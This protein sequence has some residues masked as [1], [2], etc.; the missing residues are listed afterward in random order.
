MQLRGNGAA[1]AM[2]SNLHE[3]QAIFC[4]RAEVSACG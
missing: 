1:P 4:L 3:L 2:V